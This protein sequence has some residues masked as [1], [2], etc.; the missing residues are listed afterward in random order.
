MKSKK[1]FDI[2]IF[3][4]LLHLGIYI[5]SLLFDFSRA[6]DLILSTLMLVI[7]IIN[8]FILWSSWKKRP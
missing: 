2:S 6:I 5:A 3:L 1:K 8:F 7:P 4:V